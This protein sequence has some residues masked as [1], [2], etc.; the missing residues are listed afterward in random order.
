MDKRIKLDGGTVKERVEE[1]KEFFGLRPEQ[2]FQELDVDIDEYED[3]DGELS[4]Y[5][6][7]CGLELE[8]V[9]NECSEKKTQ[10]CHHRIYKDE[11]RFCEYCGAPTTYAIE[12][13]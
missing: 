10:L 5:C 1:M 6:T 11:E 13:Q 7:M 9:P 4:N 2:S 8:K 3:E 12:K